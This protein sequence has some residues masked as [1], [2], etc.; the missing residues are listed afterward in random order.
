ML[1][2]PEPLAEISTPTGAEQAW[3][4]TEALLRDLHRAVNAD[5]ARLAIVRVPDLQSLEPVAPSPGRPADHPGTRLAQ[6]SERLAIPYLDLYPA[7][8]ASTPIPATGLYWPEDEH[9]NS[10]G[11]RLAAEEIRRWL[12]EALIP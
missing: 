2:E 9:W 12:T 7:F 3:A 4:L 6:L 11:H 8:S 1:E 5:G 10:A